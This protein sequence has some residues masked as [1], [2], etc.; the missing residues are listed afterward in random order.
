MQGDRAWFEDN[1]LPMWV[2][3][4]QTCAFLEVNEAATRHYGYSRAEFLGMTIKDIRPPEDVPPLLARLRAGFPGRTQKVIGRHMTKDKR[5][6]EVEIYA[7]PGLWNGRRA[8]FIQVR[9]ITQLKRAEETLR[10]LSGGLLHLRDVLSQI[11][12]FRADK[13]GE[14]T[15]REYEILQLL[16]EGHTSKEI[17]SALR[18]S[19]YTAETHRRNIMQ[20]LNLHSVAQLTRYAIRNQLLTP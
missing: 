16:A 11:D 19:A 9:D 5:L 4:P 13:N 18:I 3:D 2:F 14:L 10:D 12:D 20:K 7:Q 1:P 15:P 8:E 17:A 6:I